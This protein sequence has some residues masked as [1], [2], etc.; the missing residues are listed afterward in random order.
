MG[1]VDINR[2]ETLPSPHSSIYNHTNSEI[3]VNSMHLNGGELHNH[4]LV[5]VGTFSLMDLLP[6]Y[7]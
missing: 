1:K 6:D 5:K 7:I 3:T 4:C 2:I